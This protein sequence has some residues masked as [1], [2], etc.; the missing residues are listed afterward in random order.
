MSVK[1]EHSVTAKCKPEHAWQKFERMEEWP[2][3]N[4]VIGSGKWTSGKAWQSGSR[5]ALELA[6]PKKFS[7][8]CTVTDNAVPQG[9]TWKADGG[10]MSGV[11]WF[12][13]EPQGDGATVLRGDAEFSGWKTAIGAPGIQDAFRKVFTER[14]DALKTE[15]EKI[16]RETYARS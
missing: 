14:L 6:Y 3:W 15:A 12:R 16:S 2:W 7:L 10:G 9:I 1:V 11:M 8:N 4:R 13:F 5:F